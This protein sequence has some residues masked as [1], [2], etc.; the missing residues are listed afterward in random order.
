[1][2]KLPNDIADEFYFAKLLEYVSTESN[3][4]GSRIRQILKPIVDLFPDTLPDEPLLP[5]DVCIAA[6]VRIGRLNNRSLMFL[7]F[8]EA[9]S[10]FTF[11]EAVAELYGKHSTESKRTR[12]SIIN[13][14]VTQCVRD[15]EFLNAAIAE[16][17]ERTSR[18][19][20]AR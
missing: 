14:T 16:F 8:R 19:I 12:L 20:M 17:K 2:K 7:T 5:Y 10:K 13:S 18:P 3:F 15:V 1:M 4:D 11:E 6:F 9:V